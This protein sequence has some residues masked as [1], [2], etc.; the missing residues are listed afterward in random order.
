MLEIAIVG[1]AVGAAGCMAVIV[2]PWARRIWIRVADGIEQ[3]QHV[4]VEQTTKALDALF[5]EVQPTWLRFAY[6]IG[7]LIVGLTAF[8]LTNSLWVGL[9]GM[10]VGVIL[11]DVVVRQAKVAR[12]KKF[13][14][15][16][17]LL[18]ISIFY[19]YIFS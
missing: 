4:K 9:L 17:D 12:L 7:P 11:P 6:G 14:S 5:M 10:M 1:L 13:Q 8:L 16:L 2:Y 19:I 18:P 15:Q 3:L